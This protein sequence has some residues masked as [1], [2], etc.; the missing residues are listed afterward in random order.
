MKQ[1][2]PIGSRIIKT[3]MAVFVCMLIFTFGH[4]ER[5]P[6]YVLITTII[7]IQPDIND[8]KRTALNRALGT[9]I[10][11]STGAIAMALEPFIHIGMMGELFWD[12]LNAFMILCT[13]YLTVILRKQY[14]AFMACVAYLSVA[15]ISRGD[16][17]PYEF[18]F[19]RVLDTFIGVGV[20]YLVCRIRIPIPRKKNVLFIAEIDNVRK[21]ANEQLSE[22]NKTELNKVIDEGALFT[23]ITKNTPAS[24]LEQTRNLNLNLPV[25]ALDGAVLYDVNENKYLD[26]YS[27]EKTIGQ[28]IKLFLEQEN[29]NYF[30]HV[31]IEDVLIIYYDG[32]N[33][34]VQRKY[35]EKMRRSPYRNYIKANSSLKNDV[36]YFSILDTKE[37]IQKI[38]DKLSETGVYKY[39]RYWIEENHFQ[40]MDLLKI[41]SKEACAQNMIKK[42]KKELH[43]N[44][45]ISFGYEENN[46]DIVIRDNYFNKIVKSIH[47]EYEGIGN[48]RGEE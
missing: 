44:E 8:E 27:I 12:A 18:L 34:G 26:M 30:M 2:Q 40:G 23:I 46:Y 33:D 29:Y 47:K 42:L 7:C 4:V 15:T 22:F 36:L 20:G 35:Y 43:V 14:M 37:N 17:T 28:K 19:F 48:I 39:L 32:F 45:I 25:I 16:M 9:L 5:S 41:L 3:T 38:I 1:M 11:A 10:G 21:D 31:V 24:M 13:I 6:F